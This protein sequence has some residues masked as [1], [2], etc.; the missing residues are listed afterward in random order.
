M[1]SGSKL[2]TRRLHDMGFG[3]MHAGFRVEKVEESLGGA[4]AIKP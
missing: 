1:T 3:S 2:S 4:T